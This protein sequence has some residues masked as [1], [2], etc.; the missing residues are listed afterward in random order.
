MDLQLLIGCNCIPE[1]RIV[2]IFSKNR[3]DRLQ[4]ILP[5]LP[6][7][8]HPF[9]LIDDSTNK[10]IQTSIRSLCHSFSIEYH[11]IEEQKGILDSLHIPELHTFTT[12]LGQKQWSLGYNRNYALLYGLYMRMTHIIFMDDDIILPSS[13]FLNDIFRALSK[14]RL[15][16]ATIAGM[17]DDSIVGHIYREAGRILHNYTSGTFLGINLDSI[18]HYFMNIYN[19]DWIWLM[20]ENNSKPVETMGC[21]CQLPYDP[22]EDWENKIIFQEHGEILMEGVLHSNLIGNC[23]DKLED[24]A[25]WSSVINKRY[26]DVTWIPSLALPLELKITADTIAEK[27]AILHKTISP[28]EYSERFRQYFLHMPQWKKFCNILRSGAWQQ[29]E[30]MTV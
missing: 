11:G 14:E 18:N 8:D 21:V 5:S 4:R 13:K 2:V 26:N 3:P 12:P 15:I 25:F 1:S 20:L 9:V 10:E 6:T 30:T 22:L 23:R 19:E 29:I 16:S 24:S 17:P 27:L 28:K 7:K